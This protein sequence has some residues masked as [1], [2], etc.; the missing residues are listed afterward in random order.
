[1]RTVIKG[2]HG[3]LHARKRTLLIRTSLL[4]IGVIALLIMGF[5]LTHT[6]KNL[7]TVAAVVSVLPTA[8]QAVILIAVLP[9]HGRKKEEYDTVR[10]IVPKGILDTE[11]VITSKNDKSMQLDY[12]YI[13]PTG[14]YC[15]SF[16]EK[17][18]LSKTEKYIQMMMKNNKLNTHVKVFRDFKQ[19]KKR[20]GE[21]EPIDRD[22]CDEKLLK[23]EGV[24]RAISI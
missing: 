6:R 19:F 13:H 2:H 9:Y 15:F 8:N 17:L 12:A 11:L 18:D 16:D 5:T 3:Y 21:L 7:L 24:L 10:A 23:I 20:L 14:V 1:M 4:A 22:T